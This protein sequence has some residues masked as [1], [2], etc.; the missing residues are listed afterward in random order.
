M[1]LSEALNL[2]QLC[3]FYGAHNTLYTKD[4]YW[5]ESKIP[6]TIFATNNK[7]NDRIDIYQKTCNSLKIE[8]VLTRNFHETT[9]LNPN[10][11]EIEVTNAIQIGSG[12]F[13]E[14]IGLWLDREHPRTPVTVLDTSMPNEELEATVGM[15]FSMQK[16]RSFGV[17][18]KNFA[19]NSLCV[20]P[21]LHDRNL[22]L[23]EMRVA[24]TGSKKKTEKCLAKPKLLKRIHTERTPPPITL[25]D[26]ISG[27]EGS[28]YGARARRPNNNAAGPSS[29]DGSDREWG[30]F[31]PFKP[32]MTSTM[33][34]PD[35]ATDEDSIQSRKRKKAAKKSTT[36]TVLD[37]E[38]EDQ[39][40]SDQDS[41]SSESD[42]DSIDKGKLFKEP[43][44]TPQG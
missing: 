24:L 34:T 27:N 36:S 8:L 31:G 9:R 33:A 25:N 23:H 20:E 18:R 15:L 30:P 29:T 11:V 7:N 1:Q 2:Q 3:P 44:Q 14:S 12:V 26:S 10:H 13:T 16:P 37:D 43:C 4:P 22:S 42:S 19:W 32:L 5:L 17:L 21:L 39:N 41:T 40:I 35:E 28:N 6:V 38:S